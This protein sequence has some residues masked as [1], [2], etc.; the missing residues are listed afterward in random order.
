[1]ELLGVLSQFTVRIVSYTR[2]MIINGYSIAI[3]FAG[4]FGRYLKTRPS[5]L[6]FKQLPRDLENVNA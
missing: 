5:G 4:S 3:T 2:T 1:M 6:V